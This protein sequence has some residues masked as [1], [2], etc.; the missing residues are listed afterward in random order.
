MVDGIDAVRAA[1]REELRRGAH[2]IKIFTSGGVSSPTDPIWMRQF[3]APEIVAAVEEAATR[4]TYVMAH[5]YTPEAIRHAVENGVRSIEHGNLLDAPTAQLM[6]ERGAYLVPTLITYEALASE[7]AALG[8]AA[9]SQA[10][11]VEVVGAGA[12][13]VRLARAAGV[14]VGFGTD[15][16]GPLHR[17]QAHEF[18]LRGAFEK[19]I[20]VLRSA[21]SVN[22]QL[23]QRE[24]ELGVIAPGARADLVVFDGDPLEDLSALWRA[25]PMLVVQKGRAVVSRL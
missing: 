6:A 18:R 3:S 10:K 23:L 7:G 24:G 12:T 5:A 8:L 16:L 9:E 22:A 2:Q 21:T 11:L 19:P 15:L 13:A 1:S 4:A 17:L 25:A 14:K 20:D